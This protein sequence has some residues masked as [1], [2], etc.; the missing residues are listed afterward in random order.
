V[1]IGDLVYHAS[2]L[3]GGEKYLGIII[4]C[5][6]ANSLPDELPEP[7]DMW[8]YKIKW[9]DTE[10]DAWYDMEEVERVDARR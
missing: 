8:Y 4:M 5:D 6:R 1:K 9:L 3:R 10:C 2:S 7:G